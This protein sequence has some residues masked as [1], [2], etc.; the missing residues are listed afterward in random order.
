LGFH[1]AFL[2]FEGPARLKN[3]RVSGE[4]ATG[5]NSSPAVGCRAF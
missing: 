5:S 3:Q 4:R 1:H 2:R